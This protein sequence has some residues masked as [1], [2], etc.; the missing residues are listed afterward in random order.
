MH[1][2]HSHLAQRTLALWLRKWSAPTR[3]SLL[4]TFSPRGTYQD[5][6]TGGPL[7]GDALA[8]YATGL[9]ASFP[10]LDF[11]LGAIGR[12]GDGVVCVPWTMTGTQ[13]GAFRGLQ[14]TAVVR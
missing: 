1:F 8:G 9:W 12:L 6:V 5:P 4:A 11:E 13:R 3:A 2:G 10:D 14:P 7:S